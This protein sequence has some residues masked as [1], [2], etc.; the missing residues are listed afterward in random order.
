[1]EPITNTATQ[2]PARRPGA[3]NV[4]PI[5]PLTTA[6]ME[7][8][9]GQYVFYR[10]RDSRKKTR[11]VVE[12]TALQLAGL[13]YDDAW[14]EVREDKPGRLLAE[15]RERLTEWDS[16]CGRRVH[17]VSRGY[18]GRTRTEPGPLPTPDADAPETVTC[19]GHT[20]R[21]GERVCPTQAIYRIAYYPGG[22]PQGARSPKV[23]HVK[24]LTLV[25]V[26]NDRK[27]DAWITCCGRAIRHTDFRLEEPRR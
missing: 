7:R 2:T 20:Y 27:D 8:L 14:V 24:R 16:T 19:Q 11:L 1:M 18:S 25:A 15:L 22:I 17:S 21:L 13:D 12:M 9:Y 5:G 3:Y 10:A 23:F 6:D 4:E 26:G